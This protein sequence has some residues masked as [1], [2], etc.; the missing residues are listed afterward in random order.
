MENFDLQYICTVIGNLSGIPVRLYEN[1]KQVFYHS[2]SNLPKD[3]ITLYSEDIFKIKTNLGYYITPFFNYYGVINFLQHKIVIGPTRQLPA[4]EKDLRELAFQLDLINEL[5]DDFVQAM[6]S[7][8][9]MPLESIMQILCVLNHIFNKEKIKL[10]DIQIY[11][12]QQMEIKQQFE[13]ERTDKNFDALTEIHQQQELH[14]TLA[15]EQTLMNI[16]R[17]GDSAALREWIDNAPAVRG[18][19]LAS[20]QLRQQKNIFIVTATLTSRSAIRG[21]MDVDDALSLSDSYIQ[22]CELLNSM[23]NLTN[24]QYRMIMDFTE[25]VERIRLGKHPSKLVIDISNYIQHHLSEAITTED[26]AEYLFISRS[27]LSTKFKAE[28][29]V[30]LTDFIMQEKIEEAKR[31][32]RY[33]DKTSLVISSYLGFA[34]QSHFSK[35]FKKFTGKTPNE[36]RELHNK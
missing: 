3:P 17:K 4:N 34:S 29:G 24:L 19:I 16:V 25:R 21:G 28:A 5:A 12:F 7:I 9:P 11:E 36:Y 6:K 1:D 18:G 26:I 30:N 14:N 2:L 13:D 8:V 15:I 22:K 23:I 27:R 35:V 31:L 33:S 10:E 32:L 20:K